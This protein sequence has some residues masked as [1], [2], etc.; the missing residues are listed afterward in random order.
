LIHPLS[1][2]HLIQKNIE[3]VALLL[4]LFEIVNGFY[5]KVIK[6]IR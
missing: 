5:V 1:R 2:N 6:F 4:R 3:A